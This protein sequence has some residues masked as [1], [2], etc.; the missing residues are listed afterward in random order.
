MNSNKLPQE[1]RNL[2]SLA[3]P[4]G[5]HNFQDDTIYFHLPSLLDPR[6]TVFGV[7]CY[8]QIATDN[9]KNKGE[10]VTRAS[11]QK[12]VCVIATVPLYGVIQAKLELITSAYF[13]ERDFSQVILSL[14]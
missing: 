3:L 4:D 12:S 13:E 6:L 7:S 9:L 1:W 10:D 8:R 14:L 11:V 5:A 2:P